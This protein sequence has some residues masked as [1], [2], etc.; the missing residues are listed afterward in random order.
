MSV[1]ICGIIHQVFEE[2]LCFKLFS[3]M[4]IQLID[5]L[6]Q[7]RVNA[8]VIAVDAIFLFQSYKTLT[9][10]VQGSLVNQLT[11]SSLPYT[12]M[13]RYRYQNNMSCFVEKDESCPIV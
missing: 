13:Y 5:L 6:S 1:I 11:M 2:G 4:L 12:W 10:I 8:K 3:C 9:R 7:L